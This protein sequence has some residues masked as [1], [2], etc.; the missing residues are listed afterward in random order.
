MARILILANGGREHALAWK[1]E[2]HG[3]K[4]Y[5]IPGSPG[6]QRVGANINIDLNDIADQIRFVKKNDIDLVVIQQDNLQEKGY[7]DQFQNAGIPVFGASQAAARI[8]SSKICMHEVARRKQIP[9][10]PYHDFSKLELALSYAKDH[11][12]PLIV[13]ADGLAR[14]AGVVKCTNYEEVENIIRGMMSSTTFE[15]AGKSIL[16]EHCLE[17]EE[18]SI[19]VF[20]A[21]DGTFQMMPVSEDHKGLY[22]DGPNTGG[23]GVVSEPK[24]FTYC[25][26]HIAKEWFIKPILQYL[27]DKGTSFTGVL[28]PGIMQTKSGMMLLECNARFGDPETEVL[29]RRLKSDLFPI[30]FA[31]A[32]GTLR[33]IVVEWEEYAVASV[34][35]VS[36]GYGLTKNFPI[37]YPIEG[38]AEAEKI[39]G[40]V[41]F[42]GATA[43]KDNKLVTAGGRVLHVTAIGNNLTEA[44]ERAY[45]AAELIQFEGKYYRKDIGGRMITEES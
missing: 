32:T 43:T 10:A 21:K 35:L 20:V 7:V 44:L 24:N 18:Y 19:H 12:Y 40:V 14:G 41:V 39:P 36:Q 13:K 38:I 8:E 28:Y 3:H 37:G 42:H 45:E 33:D 30:L 22:V 25:D 29:M 23:M 1:L 34:A 2:R 6:I 26:E 31:C 9:M 5:G 16:V 15:D 11:V 4:V 17:G 27:Q